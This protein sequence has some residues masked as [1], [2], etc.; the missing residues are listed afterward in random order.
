MTNISN[1]GDSERPAA[2]Q[3]TPVSMGQVSG[4]TQQQRPVTMP[5]QGLN[6]A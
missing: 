6:A 4:N 1:M 5:G 3:V 2:G